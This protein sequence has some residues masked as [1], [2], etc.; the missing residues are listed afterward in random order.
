MVKIRAFIS[1]RTVPKGIDIDNKDY[2]QPFAISI[3]GKSGGNS[4]E[5]NGGNEENPQNQ[6]CNIT[7]VTVPENATIVAIDSDGNNFTSKSFSVKKGNQVTIVAYP[8]DSSTG[9]VQT[10][11]VITSEETLQDTLSY[12]FILDYSP[13]EERTTV[14]IISNISGVRTDVYD[15]NNQLLNSNGSNTISNV[16]V[17]SVIKIVASK[18]GY[19]LT[20][21]SHGTIQDNSIIG[22]NV[23]KNMIIS[24]TLESVSNILPTING[25]ETEYFAYSVAQ[26]FIRKFR[27]YFHK[28][29]IY[30]DIPITFTAINKNSSAD[31]LGGQSIIDSQNQINQEV[32]VTINIP[33]SENNTGLQRRYNFT[34][35]AENANGERVIKQFSLIQYQ[36]DVVTRKVSIITQINGTNS[37]SSEIIRKINGE[38]VSA[39]EEIDVPDGSFVT[40]YASYLGQEFVATETV[41]ANTTKTFDF[42]VVN[43]SLG[44]VTDATG[45]P[46]YT[47]ELTLNVPSLQIVKN[48]WRGELV[49]VIRGTKYIVTGQDTSGQR[50]NYTS[51]DRIANGSAI[52]VQ[53]GAIPSTAVIIDVRPASAN[54]RVTLKV[55]TVS[56]NNGYAFPNGT[57]VGYVIEAD[58]YE[59][60]TLSDASNNAIVAGITPMPVVV[61]LQEREQYVDV[62]VNT[63]LNSN[64]ASEAQIYLDGVLQGTG[65]P[66]TLEN[67]VNGRSYNLRVSLDGQTD[68]IEA[69]TASPNKVI[70]VNYG[71]TPIPSIYYALGVEVTSPAGALIEVVDYTDG[72]VYTGY[73]DLYMQLPLNHEITI[74]ITKDGYIG[75]YY[76]ADANEGGR[77]I[78]DGNKSY[79]G[80]TLDPVV[81]STNCTYSLNVVDSNNVAINDAI[82]EFAETQ[83]G[84]FVQHPGGTYVTFIGRTVYWRVRKTGYVTQVGNSGVLSGNKTD[85]VTLVQEAPNVNNNVLFVIN[86]IKDADTNVDLTDT[87]VNLRL[88]DVQQPTNKTVTQSDINEIENPSS[89]WSQYIGKF[90]GVAEKG[91]DVVINITKEGYETYSRTIAIPVDYSNNLYALDITMTNPQCEVVL[92]PINN[93]ND[94]AISPDAVYI[95]EGDD[96]FLSQDQVTLVGNRYRK[97][98][99]KGSTVFYKVLKSGYVS[100]EGSTVVNSSRSIP[101]T[102]WSAQNS[103][104]PFTVEPDEITVNHLAQDLSFVL[105]N[106]GGY[107]VALQTNME[108]DEMIDYINV[109][110]F[111][112]TAR[113]HQYVKHY[114]S[115]PDTRTRQ[116]RIKFTNNSDN[117]DI[118]YAVLI[119]HQNAQPAN[120]SIFSVLASADGSANSN[121][122]NNINIVVTDVTSNTVLNGVDDIYVSGQLKRYVVENGHT[123]RVQ[124]S[125]TGYTSFDEQ[126]VVNADTQ[127]TANIDDNVHTLEAS[128]G[129]GTPVGHLETLTVNFDKNGETKTINITS[130]DSWTVE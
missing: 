95:R 75:K 112:I 15:I 110:S 82:I 99:S 79:T 116:I 119:I 59:I 88:K 66:Y 28:L 65:S 54:A 81:P 18:D 96:N 12:N 91:T 130:N 19:R 84:P 90:G 78:M 16:L 1:K 60:A 74:Q 47:W 29:R 40:F 106:P 69:F 104:I 10:T 124:A 113:L 32:E 23:T 50:P 44:T 57:K 34:I 117:T 11:K 39:G 105:N 111:N 93:S 41:T 43:I 64:H 7:I 126:Y 109:N 26:T 80:I 87:T 46:F 4:D 5:G 14:N 35:V 55:G 33:L 63:K 45:Y 114:S 20:S 100:V 67:L 6:Y 61:Q 48:N 3:K 22:I 85:T 37:S 97:I 77:I 94:I 49:P 108:A 128:E 56:Y 30:G 121:L 38:N 27:S 107:S 120:S 71:T 103:N 25:V 68:H 123:V 101:I 118:R 83:Y 17:G 76:P 98:V 62:V 125:M 73:N 70:N 31:S 122:V 127:I 89:G 102:M 58:G 9:Y 24:L 86:S 72:Q 129:S 53:F 13:V 115:E 92:Y 2:W 52:N 51:G 42:D 21:S 36:A 8:D